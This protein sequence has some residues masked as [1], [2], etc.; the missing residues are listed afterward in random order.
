MAHTLVCGL[1]WFSFITHSAQRWPVQR[2]RLHLTSSQR[3]FYMCLWSGDALLNVIIEWPPRKDTVAASEIYSPVPILYGRVVYKTSAA[4]VCEIWGNKSTALVLSTLVL[5]RQPPALRFI[6]TGAE[7]AQSGENN[8]FLRAHIQRVRLFCVVMGRQAVYMHSR[9]LAGYIIVGHT[10]R[11]IDW[12]HSPF[13]ARGALDEKSINLA[14]A[15]KPARSLTL[16]S[17]SRC[18]CDSL[19][20]VRCA[21]TCQSSAVNAQIASWKQRKNCT[22]S[23]FIC[24]SW[25]A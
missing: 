15:H 22:T 12:L 21:G 4:A 25:N 9:T 14:A 2:A 7:W 13:T 24:L 8:T 19:V 16:A 6:S 10:G 1:A 20:C 23:Q 11:V 18:I 3:D 5:I 17:A